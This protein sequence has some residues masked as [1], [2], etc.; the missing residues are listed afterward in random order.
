MLTDDGVRVLEFENASVWAE[1][2]LTDPAT[3][4]CLLTL[5]RDAYGEFITTARVHGQWVVT[6][7]TFGFW[8]TEAEALVA[9]LEAA[10]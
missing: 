6:T 8:N 9:A 4:G 3:L 1:P 10:D 5:V 7:G 2:D